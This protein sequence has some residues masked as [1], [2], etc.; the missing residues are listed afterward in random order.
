MPAAARVAQGRE[1]SR[2]S[3]LQ[4]HDVSLRHLRPDRHSLQDGDAYYHWRGLAG[5]YGL[6]FDRALVDDAAVHG[7]MNLVETQIGDMA[8]HGR[9][10]GAALRLGRSE[11]AGRYLNC[12]A[13]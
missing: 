3:S 6:A 9:F 5:V 13:I 8:I 7:S 10:G 2:H 1:I 11:P 4:P 12:Y